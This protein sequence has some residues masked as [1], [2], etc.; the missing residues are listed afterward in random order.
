[1]YVLGL[2]DGHDAGAALLED[3]RIVYAA[4]EE[5]FTKRKLEVKFPYNAIAAALAYAKIKPTDVEHVAFTTTELTKTLE[6]I[7]PFM[8]ENYYQFRRRRILKPRFENLRH[9]IKYG[10][11]SV[12]IVPMST[13][14][15]KS[16]ISRQLRSMGFRD[17]KLHLV[18]H[19]V[20]HAATAA[21]TSP[22]K[23]SIVITIDGLGDGLSGS[24]SLLENGE[25]T[26]H[27]KIKATDSLGIF[28]EQVTNLVGMR[29]LEDEGKVMAMADYSYPFSFDE[30]RFK[31]FFRVEGTAITAKYGPLRQF[32]LLQR[33][34]WQVPR[35][36]FS[37]MAQQLLENVMVKF[38]S[39]AV[40]RF[41]VGDV[42]FAGGIFSN[43]KANMRVRNLDAVKHWYVFP[44]MGDGG[45][46]LG[47]ALYVN[48]MLTG[49]SSYD[50][51]AYLGNAYSEEATEAIVRKEEW[52]KHQKETPREQAKHAAE[53]IADG[54][55]IMWFQGR[56]E[57]GPR[58]LGDRS[59]LA[60]SDSEAVK[61]KLNTYVKRREWFQPFAPAILESEVERFLGY[62]GK[63]IDKFMTMAYMVKKGMLGIA[64]SVVNVDGSAR[65]QM[66]GDENRIYK[67]LLENLKRINGYGIM[68]NTSF[69]LHGMPI[70][71]TPEDAIGTMKTTKTKYMFMNGLF[72]TNKSGLCRLLQ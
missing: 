6:R 33:I 40:E 29:E 39:N 36:Q 55:Y 38:V 26:R 56:M 25:L 54:N 68:L 49:A 50:F 45:I 44:H 7:F 13:A 16:I 43:V 3:N 51:G 67:G 31:D 18:E 22:H 1:M 23:N 30:N 60:P 70:V 63:G 71:M 27:A 69:N 62:D 66:V 15:S 19:H 42:A 8:K 10:M 11:T 58:A 53:L 2:W 12:G 41:N 57:Y 64:K 47:S 37:Y 14:I 59:I 28:Y 72:L 35:E 24:I 34:G 46:A 65:P 52:L 48:Y 5:R 9:K 32:D 21:F 17:F 20:A 4:N 61:D